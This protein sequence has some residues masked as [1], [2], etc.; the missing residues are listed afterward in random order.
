MSHLRRYADYDQIAQ[1]YNR[2]YERNQ[3]AGV[4]KALRQFIGGRSGLRILEV[5]CGTGHWLGVLQGVENHVSG[6]DFSAEML[7]RVH[8]SLPGI[9]LIRGRADRLPWAAG[10]LDRVFCINAIHHFSDKPAFLAEVRRVLRPGGMFLTVGLDPHSGIDQWHVYDYFKESMEIDRQR[11]A[12]SERLREWMNAAGFE[13]CF[14]QEVEHWVYQI[15]AREALEQG[16]LDKAATSQ[17]SVLTEAEYEQG[18]QR[19]RA[20]MQDAQERGQTLLLT[21]DLRLY[22]TT[23]SLVEHAYDE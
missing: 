17:L 14:T 20:A 19:I 11:Y 23:A 22:G 7:A 21:V 4:E 13:N 8:T 5:G 15:P 1:T 18:I 12:S 6:L 10:S 9:D 2:R 16:R 3:Y